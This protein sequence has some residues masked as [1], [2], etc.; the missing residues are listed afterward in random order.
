[1]FCTKAIEDQLLKNYQ[2]QTLNFTNCIT[3]Y[4]KL[5]REW[6]DMRLQNIRLKSEKESL[7]LGINDYQL[8]ETLTQEKKSLEQKIKDVLEELDIRKKNV[9][10]LTFDFN[11]SMEKCNEEKEKN[12]ILSK[13]LTESEKNN[14]LLTETT[15]QN[16][17]QI[18]YLSNQ[19]E[20]SKSDKEKMSETIKSLSQENI[21]LVDQLKK[22][23]D[24][25]AEKMNEINEM[26]EEVKRRRKEYEKEIK[27]F[28]SREKEFSEQQEKFKQIVLNKPRSESLSASKKEN[29]NNYALDLGIIPTLDVNFQTRMTEYPKNIAKKFVKYHNSEIYAISCNL[30]GSVIAS[31]SGDHTIKF[32]DPIKMES[33][34]MISNENKIYTCLAF[35]NFHD[36]LL[37]GDSDKNVD[38]YNCSL[39]KLKHSMTGHSAKINSVNFLH[40]RTRCISSSDDRSVKIWDLDKAFCLSSINTVSSCQTLDYFSYE[41]TVVTGH[42]DGSLRLYSIK[43]GKLIDQKKNM[44]DAG[45]SCVRLSSN[46]YYVLCSSVDG[47]AI[48]LYD[49]RM[50]KLLFSLTDDD[51]FNTSETQ[52]VSFGP[53]DKYAFA[54]AS[55][56][57][58]V[59]WS[60]EDGMR[61]DVLKSEGQGVTIVSEYNVIAAQLFAGDSRGTL[62]IWH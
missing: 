30:N 29:T 31:C 47:T 51:Y 25:F 40:D 19:L 39:G 54:G 59:V 24:G 23:K 28:K 48:K 35:S 5:L 41:P 16:Q 22:S 45:L 26:E 60:I 11:E 1:M 57:N 27:I 12:E 7:E 3:S 38:L 32:Y 36:Y 33:K 52:K 46:N 44:F 55:G 53:D 2:K 8:I 6:N 43:E 49:L 4:Q 37:Y 62:T 15:K 14:K 9:D 61:K 18:S 10:D 17:E 56:G 20:S 34:G 58:V 42:K 13:K 50:R 21:Y